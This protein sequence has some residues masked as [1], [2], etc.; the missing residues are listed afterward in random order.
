[1]HCMCVCVRRKVPFLSVKLPG[2]QSV[3]NCSKSQQ[4]MHI[5]VVSAR[6]TKLGNTNIRECCNV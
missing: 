2:I 5:E 4:S 1:M 6:G 3:N